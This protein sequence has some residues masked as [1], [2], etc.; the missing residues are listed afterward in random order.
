MHTGIDDSPPESSG[1]GKHTRWSALLFSQLA[2]LLVV[3][4]LADT[5]IVAPT[6]VLPQLLEH[7]G[8]D[9]AAWL[10]SSAMLAGAMWAPL[11]GKCADIYGKRRMLV[12]ALLSACAGSLVCLAAPNI[13]VFVSGRLVQGAA[14]AAIFL[15]MA[16][17]RDL[18]TLRIA[19][20]VIGIVG[21]GAGVLGMATPFLYEVLSAEFGYRIVF[22]AA[23]LIALIAVIGVRS[24]IPESANKTPGTIDVA[25]AVLLGGGLAAVLSYISLGP[26]FG[27]LAGGPLLVLGGG[28]AAL[29]RWF[30]VSSRKREPVID[31]RNLDGP[32]ALTLLVIVLGAGAVRAIDPIISII[33]RVSP[34][35]QLGYGIAGP[36]GTVGL[37]FA[38]PG[39][40]MLIAGTLAGW[41]ATRVGPPA[42]LAA[43]AA[44]GTVGTIGMLLGATDLYAALFFSFLMALSAGALMTS[45]FNM[46]AVHAREEQQAVMSSL[47]TV[48]TAISSV[49][50][51]FVVSAVFSAT[52]TVVA[53]ENVQSATGVF[54]SIGVLAGFYALA[55]VAAGAL[56]R[57]LG[58]TSAYRV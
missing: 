49:V 23:A 24:L 16:I 39:V 32:L 6:M 44:I 19:M 43:G 21:T 35:E 51:T 2:A 48:M 36:T 4:A 55:A 9:Q 56:V 26:E 1:A 41:G 38:L 31:I 29:A 7:F 13:W 27:W 54:G 45:G 12:I 18:C 14:V 28:T 11:I 42:T 37:L 52:D 33:A 40:G 50:M 10:T 53:G 8:T 34:D 20:P 46:V 17:V 22:V 15:S 58:I 57:R 47:V 5:V 3:N 25:G 30:L